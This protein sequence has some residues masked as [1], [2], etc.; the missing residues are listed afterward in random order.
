[1]GQ[2]TPGGR[3]APPRLFARLAQRDSTSRARWR[4]VAGATRAEVGEAALVERGWNLGGATLDLR[5]LPDDER[6]ELLALLDRPTW[7][8]RDTP[9]A[10]EREAALLA[11]CPRLDAPGMDLDPL[12][13]RFVVAWP[14]GELVEERT[15]DQLRA[16]ALD[17]ARRLAD[18]EGRRGVT[19]R[20]AFSGGPARAGVHVEWGPGVDDLGEPRLLRALRLRAVDVAGEAGVPTSETVAEAIR[21]LLVDLRDVLAVP[22]RAG[23]AARTAYQNVRDAAAKTATLTL[24][25]DPGPEAA[26]ALLDRLVAA[27]GGGVLLDLAPLNHDS[28]SR[29]RQFRALGGLHKV[30]GEARKSLVPWSAPEGSAITREMIA[31]YVARLDAEELRQRERAAARSARGGARRATRAVT[32]EDRE[33]VARVATVGGDAADR[34]LSHEGALALGTVVYRAG[35]PVEVAEELAARL[36]RPAKRADRARVARDGFTRTADRDARGEVSLGWSRL[37]EELGDERVEELRA[38][39]EELGDE[40]E[41]A[42]P[43]VSVPRR[44]PVV[45]VPERVARFERVLTTPGAALVDRSPTGLGKTFSL[46]TTL[47][48]LYADADPAQRPRR[49]VVAFSSHAAALAFEVELVKAAELEGL[50]LPR[51]GRVTP[52]RCMA[53]LGDEERQ[54]RESR[55]KAAAARGWNPTRAVCHWDSVDRRC[56]FEWTREDGSHACDWRRESVQ[57]WGADVVLGM[58]AHLALAGFWEERGADFVRVVVEEDASDVLMTPREM[59][60]D[61]LERTIARLEAAS[62]GIRERAA[63]AA[64]RPVRGDPPRERTERG[65]RAVLRRGERRAEAACAAREVLRALLPLLDAPEGV[66]VL[67]DLSALAPALLRGGRSPLVRALEGVLF[68]LPRDWTR[69]HGDPL[70]NLPNLLPV[71]EHVAREQ[72]AGREVRVIVG[73]KGDVKVLGVDVRRSIPAGRSVL[74]LDASAHR[75]LLEADLARPVE[76]LDSGVPSALR[77]VQLTDSRWSRTH[78]GLTPQAREREE[79]ATFVRRVERVALAVAVIVRREGV[80]R[81][82]VVTFKALAPDLLARLGALCP[83]VRFDALHFGALRGSNELAGVE[84]L[85]VVGTPSPPHHEVVRRAVRLGASGAELEAGPRSWPDGPGGRRWGYASPV[86]REAEHSLVTAE[87]VQA[88]GRGPRGQAVPRAG[89]FLF[90]SHDLAA[91]A[92]APFP[93]PIVR[94][95]LRGAALDPAADRAWSRVEAVLAAEPEVGARAVARAAGVPRRLAARVLRAR[96]LVWSGEAPTRHAGCATVAHSSSSPFR[97]AGHRGAPIGPH[98]PS[99]LPTRLGVSKRALAQF[100]GVPEPS[101]RRWLSGKPAPSEVVERA[102]RHLAERDQI[103]ALSKAIDWTVLGAARPA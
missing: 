73:G 20:A 58:K 41:D 34:G 9:G 69:D 76:V 29:G 102:E 13:C 19:V 10:A 38:L 59:R 32:P 60:R 25:A 85:V 11:R 92:L 101:L 48:R 43:A 8:R 52:Q 97:E 54:E 65:R 1:M 17:Y 35:A 4:L 6:E 72:A 84:V 30:G 50:R 75:G 64:E 100:L 98:L 39:L 89:V 53:E 33:A 79:P 22:L 66:Y 67:P 18:V 16:L 2:T 28:G 82:G 87:L 74:V 83:T 31:P 63:R 70:T 46:A 78:F 12:A 88:V 93:W 24:K 42:A 40:D 91:D 94:T 62:V 21:A 81:A 90:S 27:L 49:V 14:G 3:G 55:Y 23:A 77:V 7:L 71:V 44:L 99:D 57:A 51:V 96:R 80:E 26:R 37:A 103:V 68:T 47:V 45:D 36:A 15:T 86:M 61:A 56:E 95:T 5:A